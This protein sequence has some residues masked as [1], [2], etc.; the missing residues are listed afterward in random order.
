M[1]S[2]NIKYRNLEIQKEREHRQRDFLQR[3]NDDR[4]CYLSMYIYIFILCKNKNYF[5]L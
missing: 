1:F 5:I 3:Y 2:L 4:K